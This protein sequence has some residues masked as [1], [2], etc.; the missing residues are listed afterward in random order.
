MSTRAPP[1]GPAPPT[2]RYL[3]LLS[4]IRGFALFYSAWELTSVCHLELLSIS[5]QPNYLLSKPCPFYKIVFLMLIRARQLEAEF[6]VVVN[7]T[8][9]F[10]SWMGIDCMQG[11]HFN[12]P[13]S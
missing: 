5:I 12:R 10:N 13:V 4:H 9:S 8:G 7:K 6:L 2:A 1:A 11:S 3:S